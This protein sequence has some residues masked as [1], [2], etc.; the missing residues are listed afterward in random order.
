MTPVAGDITFHRGISTTVG[1][2]RLEQSILLDTEWRRFINEMDKLRRH[3]LY[4]RGT[5]PQHIQ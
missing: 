5:D 1:Q 4:R 2:Y 3:I